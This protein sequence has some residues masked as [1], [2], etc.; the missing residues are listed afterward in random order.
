VRAFQEPG[1]LVACDPPKGQ[2]AIVAFLKEEAKRRR[3]SLQPGAAEALAEAV[4]P[5]LLMLRQELE[6][7]ALHAGPGAPVGRHDVM[8]I[9]S[10]VAEEPIWDLTDAIGEGRTPDALVVLDRLLGSGTPPPVLLGSLASHF[11]RLVRSR[12]GAS[13]GGHPFLIKKLESQAQRYSERRLVACL[14]AIHQVDE[15]LKG[16]GSLPAG[17]A[18]ERLVMGLSA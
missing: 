7:A 13:V 18:L 2:R 12:S 5:Q 11:R 17:I 15:A 6:K 14:H 8:A 9:A 16:Q 1:A 10:D 4:G 3:I